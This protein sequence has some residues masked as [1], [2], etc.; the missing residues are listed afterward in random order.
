MATE[1]LIPEEFQPWDEEPRIRAL[2]KLLI[3]DTPREDAF[4]RI[5]KLAAECSRT[6]ISLLS[7]VDE[8]R[9]WVKSGFGM[10]VKELPREHSFG[11]NVIRERSSFVVLD[12]KEDLRFALNALVRR[13]GIRFYAGAPVTLS[14]HAV[15]VLCVMDES[16]RRRYPR[17][18]QRQLLSLAAMSSDELELRLLRA[19]E[20][21][22]APDFP[23][24]RYVLA[25]LATRDGFWDWDLESDVL[26][27]SPRWQEILGLGDA[28]CIDRL[29]HW[30]Q[31][32]HPQD[33][34]RVE[35]ELA[36]H[37]RGLTL[38][39][40]SEHRIRH[41]DRSWRWVQVRGNTVQ[42][43]GGLA[44]RMGGAMVDVTEKKTADPLTNLPNRLYLVDRL[45]R[46]LEQAAEA[47]DWS[48]SLF[49]VE[50]DCC[51]L[52][53]DALGQ[54]GIE[55]GLIEIA[56]RLCSSARELAPD[57]PFFAARIKKGRFALIVE[58][59]DTKAQAEEAAAE[60]STTICSPFTYENKMASP[61]AS[62]G[63]ALGN[64]KYLQPEDLL[65]DA[66]NALGVAAGEGSGGCAVFTEEMHQQLSGRLQ[67]YSD[68]RRAIEERKLILYYQPEVDLRM[69][70][71]V[72][73]EALLRWQHPERG[74]VLPGDFI[75]LAEET[76]LILSLGD[77]GLAEASRQLVE[78]RTLSSTP[79]DLRMSVNLS[80]KEFSRPGLLKRVENVLSS[81]GLSPQNLRL[82]VTESSLI[83]DSDAALATMNGLR[84]MGI[85]LHLD[86]FGTGYSSLNYLHRFPF[87]TLKIDRS[88]I[89]RVCYHKESVEIVRTILD[90]AHSLNMEVVAEGIET[91]DQLHCLRSL[92]CGYGQGYY[93]ARP[94]APEAVTSLLPFL[95][96][97]EVIW[98]HGMLMP[99][100]DRKSNKN[101]ACSRSG[102]QVSDRA[103]MGTT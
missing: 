13:V 80:A 29:S 84:E 58:G 72:G 36:D 82:E 8:H 90:L 65:R 41:R 50:V 27:C 38:V 28:E 88:F 96:G 103:E 74:M 81:S 73:F 40:R 43:R 53:I 9:L 79:P 66:E 59:L 24:D 44:T 54:R 89:Q 69:N 75:P 98:P 70:R 4:D 99:L 20:T 32:V 48:F 7:F 77:W 25:S 39:F 55:A 85:G 31:R 95:G 12:A 45:E 68:L 87:D 1:I 76:G 93:F 94:L 18:A 11:L 17:E 35:A 37:R 5:T 10:S 14:G 42:S 61:L 23:E 19:G 71:V 16:R 62:I 6:P 56:S 78:W 26:Y 92:G 46:R 34:A 60:I 91:L 22:K 3:L 52:M 2:R 63:V 51:S 21:P 100:H 49:F 30:M 64:R 101:R 86:D 97:T 67:L 33:R 47:G 83:K 15:G 57:A 102:I